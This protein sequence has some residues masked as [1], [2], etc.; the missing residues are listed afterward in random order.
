M[1][2][3]SLKIL[4]VDD[5]EDICWALERMLRAAGYSVTSVTTAEGALIL[6]Y[7]KSFALAFVDAKLPGMDGLALAGLI[8]QRSPHTAIILI[9]GYF[10]QEDQ[11]ISEAVRNKLLVGFVAKPFELD[12]IRLFTRQALG[13]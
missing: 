5:E 11:A 12:E 10:Y 7:Q 1:E 9:S 8:H 2:S 3:Q 6:L 4:V 13:N